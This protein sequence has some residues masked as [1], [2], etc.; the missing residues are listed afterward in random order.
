MVGQYITNGRS[1]ILQMVGQTYPTE[2]QLNTANFSDSE[3]L[4]GLGP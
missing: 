3:A 4:F 2:Y 1:N